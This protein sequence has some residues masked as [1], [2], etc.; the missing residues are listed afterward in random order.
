MVVAADRAELI[1]VDQVGK[2]YGQVNAKRQQDLGVTEF[3]WRTVGDERV[4]GNPGG[5]YP[6]ATPSH[7]DRDSKTYRYDDPPKGKS[8]EK[9]LP[10]VPIRC[11]CSA[12]PKLDHLLD[13]LPDPG[14]AAG[15][16]LVRVAPATVAPP[17]DLAA[18][19]RAAEEAHR[20]LAV[21]HAAA[22][23][24]REAQLVAEREAWDLARATKMAGQGGAPPP[25]E[26]PPAPP[27]LPPPP[28]PAT[29]PGPTPVP[30]AAPPG[31]PAPPAPPAPPGGGQPPSP[32]PSGPPSGGGPPRRVPPAGQAAID[33]HGARED[34]RRLATSTLEKLVLVKA[35][36]GSEV[37]RAT[38]RHDDGTASDAIWKPAPTKSPVATI[39]PG[40]Q[41]TRERIASIVAEQLGVPD[42]VPIATT[43]IHGGRH[44]SIATWMEGDATPT[45]APNPDDLAR[46]RIY[47]FVIG[48]RDRHEDNVIW[49]GGKPV[50][51][52][53]GLTFPASEADQF[54]YP[55]SLRHLH[56]AI[57]PTPLTSERAAFVAGLDERGLVDTLLAAG[58]DDES[59]RHTVY[60]VAILKRA[61]QL[62]ASSG[63][64]DADKDRWEMA[65]IRTPIELT[66]AERATA[67][68]LLQSRKP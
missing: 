21:E 50:L 13:D 11:R 58:L 31:P 32:P 2:L 57:G 7:W 33:D 38:L 15:A 36:K 49:Q 24:G 43:R 39:P 1:A 61:P 14:E 64:F 26:A 9:E 45:S 20:Q 42:L 62:L 34:V 19:T 5:L 3:I 12:E 4:R 16:D 55:E 66:A 59:I 60:R 27:P 29:P 44:G 65:L 56:D 8:G 54:D 52:D 67:N 37:Y 17:V 63:N 18:L 28:P 47:D 6:K 48:N 25:P 35:T 10:G 53:H 41:P 40:E 68:R 30:P 22:R 23:A 51:I 46:M